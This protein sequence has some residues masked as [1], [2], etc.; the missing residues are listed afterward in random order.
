[1]FVTTRPSTAAAI[2]IADKLPLKTTSKVTPKG[3][4]KLPSALSTAGE[5]K[6][7]GQTHR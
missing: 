6:T 7:A 4:L 1:M 2:S 5:R 3:G